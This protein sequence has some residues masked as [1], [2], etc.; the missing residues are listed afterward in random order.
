MVLEQNVLV[1]VLVAVLVLSTMIVLLSARLGM[2][3]LAFE[4]HTFLGNKHSLW[5][6]QAVSKIFLVPTD[7]L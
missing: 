1:V 2:A 5:E 6:I 4:A 3:L 7:Q